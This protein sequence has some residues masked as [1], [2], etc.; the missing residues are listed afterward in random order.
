MFL[1]RR[2]LIVN[3][4]QKMRFNPPRLTRSSCQSKDVIKRNFKQYLHDTCRS[5][6]AT[7]KCC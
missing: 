6:D 2:K 4:A 3:P 5:K 7:V 1:F